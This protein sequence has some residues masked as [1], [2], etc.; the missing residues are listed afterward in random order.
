MRLSQLCISLTAAVFLL[1]V[2]VTADAQN[3]NKDL[4]EAA[5]E[6]EKAAK[7]LKTAA[8]NLDNLGVDVKGIESPKGF[9]GATHGCSKKQRV[10]VNF[11][12]AD[13]KVLGDKK[14]KLLIK[15]SGHCSVVIRNVTLR[16][17]VVLDLSGHANVLLK[18]VT[19]EGKTRG[20]EIS[21]HASL[22]VR[23]STITAGKK[24]MRVSGHASVNV[25]R[26]KI[27]GKSMVSGFGSVTHDSAST[28]G[29]LKK[30]GRYSTI[31][32]R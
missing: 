32:K 16:G 8:K 4:V 15:A 28:F 27:N 21:G 25:A 9:K 24:A 14:T 10:I 29:K 19:I 6:L 11:K 1:A 22:A 20:I 12:K 23:D 5:K 18:N 2:P 13:N 31:R 17:D 3:K 30:S 7:D 26:S